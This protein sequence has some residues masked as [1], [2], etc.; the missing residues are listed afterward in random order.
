MGKGNLTMRKCTEKPG[1]IECE[2][3]ELLGVQFEACYCD[4]DLCNKDQRCTCGLKCQTC[5]GE[6][7]A[8]L[9]SNDNGITSYCLKGQSCAYVHQGRFKWKALELFIFIEFLVS[10]MHTLIFYHIPYLANCHDLHISLR[11]CYQNQ[12]WDIQV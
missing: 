8:C 4:S 5:L 1:A 3:T 6:D 2:E 12:N 11:N 10:Y 9:D 7:G